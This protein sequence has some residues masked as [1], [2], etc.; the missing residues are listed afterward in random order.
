MT[1]HTDR[2]EVVTALKGALPYLRLFKG[3]TFVLKAGGALCGDFAGLKALAVQ[4]ETL[5]EIGIRVVLVHGGGPQTTELQKRLGIETVFVEGR[6]VTCSKTLDVAVQTMNGSAST[7]ILAACRAVGMPALGLSGIDAGL[8]KARRR[9]P[10]NRLV[11]GVPTVVD[12][13]HVGDVV[14]VDASVL[15]RL[16]DAGFVPVVSPLSADDDGNVLNIN[17]DTVA[18]AIARAMRAEK[19]IFLTE[20]PG[21]LEDRNDPTSLISFIDAPGIDGLIARGVIDAGMLPK[22]NAAKEALFG[23]VKRVHVISDRTPDSVLIE[24]FTNEG[25]GTLIVMDTRDLAPAEQSGTAEVSEEA[26]S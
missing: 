4:V 7:A 6:R 14:S 23:G 12:Y 5:R 17:A 11:N 1:G 13:G 21:I 22:A 9:P 26:A 2:R 24:V 8:V 10:R 25:C 19:L 16:L 15:T 20:A 3:K 18:S